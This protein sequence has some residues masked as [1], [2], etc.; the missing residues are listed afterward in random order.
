MAENS[1]K[2][3]QS[4]Q[5]TKVN[6]FD[7]VYSKFTLVTTLDRSGLFCEV[8]EGL[9]MKTEYSRDELVGNSFQLLAG[10]SPG[11]REALTSFWSKLREG[12]TWRGE[13]RILSKSRNE[14]WIDAILV[15]LPDEEDVQSFLFVGYDV[16]K[17][18]L[19]SEELRLAKEAE[20]LANRAKS[21]F[22]AMMSHEVRTPING[23]LGL[24]SLL[25]DSELQADQ[26][27][28]ALA[29][30][31]SARD[32]LVIIND[33]LDFSKI[34]AGKLAIESAEIDLNVLLEEIIST[35]NYMV[36][37]KPLKLQLS[38]PGP[39]LSQCY[40]GD[41]GR[42]R[43]I[44]TNLINN[45]IKFTPKG[46]I[47]VS[48][49]SLS[50][51]D[52]ESY[53]RFEVKDQGIGIPK[54]ALSKIF[55]AFSQ[56]DSTTSRRFGGTGLGLSICRHLVHLMDG[57]IS[58]ESVEGKGSTFRFEM[59]LK[60]GNPRNVLEKKLLHYS[61]GASEIQCRRNIRV[62]VVEDNS[63]NRV[64]AQKQLEKLGYQVD[65]VGSGS[66]ALDVLRVVPYNVVLMDCQ[67]PELDG[68]E[69]TRRIRASET[70][71]FC[72][73]P[74]IAM[75]ANALEGDREQCLLCGMND[76]VSKPIELRQLDEV[77]QMWGTRYPK[78][79]GDHLN[80]SSKTGGMMKPESASLTRILAEPFKQE[81]IEAL[82]QNQLHSLRELDQ[83]GQPSLIRQLVEMFFQSFPERM[84]KME[85]ALE[86]ND[87]DN[88]KKQAHQLKSS[89]GNLGA[90][91]LFWLFQNIEL[92]ESLPSKPLREQLLKEIGLEFTQVERALTDEIRKSA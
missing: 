54:S 78:S 41:P 34:E 22:L 91:K 26:R 37:E 63:I 82:D 71:P 19:I 87:L 75:T 28:Y 70:M 21:K 1:E 43:Q 61:L 30:R 18:R 20:S 36:G 59:W 16:T 35:M 58:V 88:A 6:P 3:M 14:L 66:E 83:P 81:S 45:A 65:V 7:S 56:A 84:E 69:T 40:F 52:S 2:M 73:I 72:Q 17:F 46:T 49:Q 4:H 39:P 74:I 80:N 25:L 90:M 33:I 67:M 23:V 48:V 24:S 92:M 8:S 9:I 76:Y 13:I 42:L 77:L 57:S 32:L 27:E 51:N 12:R 64:V 44:L 60:K 38:F 62:L 5:D 15:P 11:S 79:E 29:I 10:D 89:S 68:Y 86:K 85:A 53:L 55:D 50:E 31:S 47:E